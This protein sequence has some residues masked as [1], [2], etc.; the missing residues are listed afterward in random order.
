MSAEREYK[1]TEEGRSLLVYAIEALEKANP[2]YDT[3]VVRLALG[4]DARPKPVVAL[5][6][7]S[8]GPV[9]ELYEKLV[10]LRAY[11]ADSVVVE[12]SGSGDEGSVHSVEVY[13]AG[14]KP[15]APTKAAAALTLTRETENV[16]SE[17][18][19]EKV[20]SRYPGWENNEGGAGTITIGL[21]AE[22]TVE[23]EHGTAIE[24]Y[25]YETTENEIK[26][27][28]EQ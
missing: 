15:N 23:H 11:G 22:I 26:E 12:Y 9:S 20:S 7:E 18:A 14:E 16:I 1:F 25:E 27:E 24:E 10:E 5:P 4:M 3:T 28:D 19:E 8:E 6:P 21:G 17:W 2:R 13:R